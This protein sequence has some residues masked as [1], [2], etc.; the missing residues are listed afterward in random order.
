MPSTSALHC[1]ALP[2][3]SSAHEVRAQTYRRRSADS[4]SATSEHN[5]GSERY[6]NSIQRGRDKALGTGPGM[7]DT[8][9]QKSN[10]NCSHAIL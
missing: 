10:I 3:G 7:L 6:E 8:Q 5:G 1:P 9:Y 4:G 2:M